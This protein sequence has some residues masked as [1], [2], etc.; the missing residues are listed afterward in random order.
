MFEPDACAT[1]LGH[2]FDHLGCGFG[3]P[4]FFLSGIYE[5]GSNQVKSMLC[6]MV[7]ESL[8]YFVGHLHSSM[9][10]EFQSEHGLFVPFILITYI[11]LFFLNIDLEDADFI[12]ERCDIFTGDWIP[13]SPCPVYTNETSH[14]IKGHQNCMSNGHPGSG[15]LSCLPLVSFALIISADVVV[16]NRGEQSH[17]GWQ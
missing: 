17:R 1:E 15:Y 4:W 13:N 8:D 7:S 5:D 10:E 2:P 3:L 16:D 11:L 12:V 9:V 14:A 6:F